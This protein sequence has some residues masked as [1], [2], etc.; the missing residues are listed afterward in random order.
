MII[1]NDCYPICDNCMY[2]KDDSETDEFTGAGTCKYHKKEVTAIEY[3]ENFV[4]FVLKGNKN[5]K[6]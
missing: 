3:C 2:Y 6:N 1:P 4:C 5:V